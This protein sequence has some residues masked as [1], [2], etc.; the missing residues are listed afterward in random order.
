VL[1]ISLSKRS[2]KSWADSYSLI[3]ITMSF[4]PPF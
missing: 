3:S 4:N 2:A 1:A